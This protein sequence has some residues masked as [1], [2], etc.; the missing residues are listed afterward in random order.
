MTRTEYDMIM[1]AATAAINRVYEHTLYECSDIAFVVS[2]DVFDAMQRYDSD[3]YVMDNETFGYYRNIKIGVINE[4]AAPTMAAPAIMGAEYYDGMALDDIIVVDE[5]NHLFQLRDINPVRFVDRGY[6]VRFDIYE[7]NARNTDYILNL[8]D[9]GGTS[10]NFTLNDVQINEQLLAML[11]GADVSN[12]R[13]K[14]R[15]KA[16]NTENLAPGDTKALD[17]FI[18]GFAIKQTLRQARGD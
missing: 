8:I 17:E 7:F 15:K 11:A 10:V 2:Y 16:C 18:N 5:E 1:G 9:A 6:T 13:R 3:N 14:K 4:L 12:P